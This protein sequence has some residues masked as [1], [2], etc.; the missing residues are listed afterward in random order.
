MFIKQK[1]SLMDDFV[2]LLAKNP[3]GFLTTTNL[4]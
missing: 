1:E 2:D 3:K 4:P